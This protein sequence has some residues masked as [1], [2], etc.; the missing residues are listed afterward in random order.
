MKVIAF[1]EKNPKHRQLNYPEEDSFKYHFNGNK[2][3]LVAV[4]DG[5]TRDPKGV[6][7]H[8]DI[9]DGEE[10]IK[11][12]SENYPRPSP[13]K[14]AANLF[15]N[16]FIDYMKKTKLQKNSIRKAMEYAN[17]KISKLN[18][19]LEVD[20][21]ENDFAGCVGVVGAIAENKLYYG[22]VADCGAC[23]FSKNGKLKFR[24]KNEGPNSNGSIN[25]EISKKYNVNPKFP[26]GRK[27][28]RSAYR[29][30]VKNL[31]SYGAFTGEESVLDFVKTRE[32]QLEQGDYVVFYSDGAPPIIF[33]E[34]FN[35]SECFNDLKEYVN[36]NS[37]KI[38]GGEGTLVAIS[39]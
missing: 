23:I 25:E 10:E 28:I 17:K 13:A 18:E 29:N 38:G 1:T 31:L 39:L 19:G 20:Y 3:L 12:A 15:C 14:K 32:T 30:N 16:S 37:E 24:T 27:I 7:K 35:I 5:I 34:N 11:K 4:A 2:E 26:K 6:E 36:K 33:S 8:P 9:K 21:L 22:Y